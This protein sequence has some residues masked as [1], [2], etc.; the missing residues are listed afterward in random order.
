MTALPKTVTVCGVRLE[1]D[2]IMESYRFADD[3]IDIL[4][5]QAHDFQWRKIGW[6]A[7]VEICSRRDGQRVG[8]GGALEINTGT[9]VSRSPALA[10]RALTRLCKRFGVAEKIGGGR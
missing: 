9:P 2:A 3:R 1:L 7:R 4:V 8:G 6:E 5:S 10:A